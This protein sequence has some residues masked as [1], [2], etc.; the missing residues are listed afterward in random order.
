MRK[1]IQLALEYYQYWKKIQAK[2]VYWFYEQNNN[3][4]RAS[5]FFLHFFDDHCTTTRWNLP[6]RRFVEDV[7][8][9]RQIFISLF[10]HG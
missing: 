5:R 9:R 4:A 1:Y 7:D 6:M 3:S 2:E 8:I 10:E